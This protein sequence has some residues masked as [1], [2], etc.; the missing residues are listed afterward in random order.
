MDLFARGNSFFARANLEDAQSKLIAA[1]YRYSSP[2]AYAAEFSGVV[3]T[4][5]EE[6]EDILPGPEF[7]ETW[8]TN[9]EWDWFEEHEEWKDLDYPYWGDYA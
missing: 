2:G 7:S 8:W 4:S 9:F 5:G 3:N 1:T 6:F